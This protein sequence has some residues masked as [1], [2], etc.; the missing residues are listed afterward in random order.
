[1]AIEHDVHRG[2]VVA[3]TMTQAATDVEH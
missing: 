2:A 3:L 1:L